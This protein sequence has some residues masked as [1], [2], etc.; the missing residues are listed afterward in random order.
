MAYLGKFNLPC[1]EFIFRYFQLAMHGWHIE[2]ISTYNGWMAYLG[3]FNLP[4][5]CGVFRY[6]KLTMDGWHI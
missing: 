1:M 3:N 5:M 2:V 4:W 6:V